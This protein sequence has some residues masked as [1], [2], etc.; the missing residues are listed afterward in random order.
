MRLR[1]K[2]KALKNFSIDYV[3]CLHFDETLSQQSAEAF[4]KNILVDKLNIKAILVGDEFR[5]GAKRSGDFVLLKQLGEQ[6]GFKAFQMEQQKYEDKR[7]SSSRIREALA[8]GDL[9]LAETLL[10]RPYAFCGKVIRG[11]QVG[12]QLGFPTANIDLHRKISPLS[13]IFAARVLGLDKI[14]EGAAYVGERPTLQG[15]KV[16]CEVFIFD[17]NRTIYGQE[18]TI[19]FLHKIRD[20]KRLDSLEDLQRQ[21]AE[22]IEKIKHWFSQPL[23]M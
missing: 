2:L 4:T 23:K 11:D 3:L 15:T 5:Y 7:I 20:D 16:L 8:A 10:G 12:I 22:D 19:E 14:Y 13:G 18:L 9:K 1:E 17:F 21:I 6:Y